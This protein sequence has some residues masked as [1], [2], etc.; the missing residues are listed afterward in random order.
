MLKNKLL[1]VSDVKSINIIQAVSNRYLHN[2]T[3][4]F[5][6]KFLQLQYNKHCS[7]YLYER[8]G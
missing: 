4:V 6:I 8:L 1:N 5:S 7:L 3:Y 2:V